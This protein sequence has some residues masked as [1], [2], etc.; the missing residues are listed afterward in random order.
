M[1]VAPPEV[2]MPGMAGGEKAKPMAPLMPAS[3]WLMP[4]LMVSYCSSG[5]LRAAHSSRVMKKK[6]CRF[7]HAAHRL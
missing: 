5:V 7:G 6:C 4:L 2:P 3:F 1:N